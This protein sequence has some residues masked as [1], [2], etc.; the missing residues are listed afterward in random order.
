MQR[1]L[2]KKR[3]VT[4]YMNWTCHGKIFPS[5]EPTNVG[6]TNVYV[7]MVV[8][9]VAPRFNVHDNAAYTD[10]APN[11]TAEKFY[12]LL[13]DANEPLLDGCQNHTRLS[14]ISQLLNLKFEFYISESC[15]DHL[16]LLTK[17][18]LP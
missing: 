15:F 7:D 17:S 13:R 18:I 10:E 1:H 11:K 8:N 12:Q 9:A 3:F 6:E 5:Y 14:V 4:G 2:Y 16:L